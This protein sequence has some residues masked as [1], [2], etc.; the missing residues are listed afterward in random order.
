MQF[1]RIILISTGPFITAA[2]ALVSMIFLGW[3]FLN[4]PKYL[5]AAWVSAVSF[6]A[7][8]YASAS[9]LQYNATTGF[10]L[11]LAELFQYSSLI[12]T[13]HCVFGFTFV[14]LKIN[15]KKYHQVIGC[16][17]MLVLIILWASDLI[18]GTKLIGREMTWMSAPYIEPALGPLASFFHGYAVVS[19]I[20]IIFIWFQRRARVGSSANIFLGGL[21]FGFILGLHDVMGMIGFQIGAY[22]MIYGFLSFI[23]AVMLVT[24][25][26]YIQIGEVLTRERDR[27]D[28]TV[29]SMGYGFITTDLTEH[30]LSYN[31]EAERLCGWPRQ[32]CIG[33]HFTEVYHVSDKAGKARENLIG[34]VTE[35]GGSI[36][37]F[38][39]DV[40]T[41][42][43]KSSRKVVQTFSPVRA[44]DD[45]VTG[46]VIVF[47]TIT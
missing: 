8:V 6:W 41:S 18:V 12:L 29:E 4:N 11:R 33:K 34:K 24:I 1:D 27:L 46:M 44:R 43:D 22:I 39:G 36:V 38:S 26:S 40:L 17:H 2:I 45:T 19:G 3:F 15:G 35:H 5:A 32:E 7:F 13:I 21:L 28:F 14:F 20:V 23:T 47:F 42:R 30:I 10:Y 16:F 9:F 25:N 31:K 37:T